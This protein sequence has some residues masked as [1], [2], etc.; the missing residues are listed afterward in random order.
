MSL[1]RVTAATAIR[2]GPMFPDGRLVAR[3]PDG[4]ALFRSDHGQPG[5]CPVAQS[6]IAI[7]SSMILG[8]RP[9][10]AE[11][12]DCGLHHRGNPAP[13]R[14]DPAVTQGGCDD[15]RF[16]AVGAASVD[17]VQFHAFADIML[18]PHS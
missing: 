17:G 14:A 6:I 11:R 4:F 16:G 15:F 12:A 1:G 9:P 3:F 10:K 8:H 7:C 13:G 5:N 18:A 2:A